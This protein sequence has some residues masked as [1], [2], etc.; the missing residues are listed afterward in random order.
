MLLIGET[1]IIPNRL[2]LTIFEIGLVV[3]FFEGVSS[4]TGMSLALNRLEGMVV[5]AIIF[6]MITLLGGG[7]SQ[8]KKLWGWVM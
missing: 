8:G 2:V 4:P 1:T 6:G 3:T 7:L 5:G